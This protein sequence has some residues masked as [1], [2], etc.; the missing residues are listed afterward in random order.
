[1]LDLPTEESLPSMPVSSARRTARESGIHKHHAA[2]GTWVKSHYGPGFVSEISQRQ[3]K[4]FSEVTFIGGGS[5]QICSE[6]IDGRE[7]LPDQCTYAGQ[8]VAYLLAPSMLC[9][10]HKVK[11]TR[12][13]KCTT[14]KVHEQEAKTRRRKTMQQLVSDRS[15]LES[16]GP[17]RSA[18]SSLR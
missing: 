11:H 9:A 5:I 15:H 17:I 18:Q 7:L 13:V 6:E 14:P 8:L 4:E 10:G 2:M 16:P 3:G 12:H 1:M